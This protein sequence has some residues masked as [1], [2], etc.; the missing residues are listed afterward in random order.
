[1]VPPAVARM[2]RRDRF[3][4]SEIMLPQITASDQ[5]RWVLIMRSSTLDVIPKASISQSLSVVAARLK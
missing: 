5:R 2:I 1:V 3:R 4:S